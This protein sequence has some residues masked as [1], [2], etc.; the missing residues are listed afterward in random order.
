MALFAA[1]LAGVVIARK[2]PL[3]GK[4]GIWAWSFDYLSQANHG[5][6]NHGKRCAPDNAGVLLNNLSLAVENQHD[7]PF[8]PADVERFIILVEH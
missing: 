1:I 3:A 5:W 6:G 4:F 7:G 2:N 8:D